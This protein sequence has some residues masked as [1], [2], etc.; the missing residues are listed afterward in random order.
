[1]DGKT[2]YQEQLKRPEWKAV[3]REVY[4]RDAW[5]CVDCG[6]RG[7]TLDCHHLHY[8]KGKARRKRIDRL[9]RKG[10]VWDGNGRFWGYVDK[11]GVSRFFD[12]DGNPM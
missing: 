6:E 9:E 2:W 1:M 7:V 8:V 4:R 12:E 10:A 5:A 11:K 3:R